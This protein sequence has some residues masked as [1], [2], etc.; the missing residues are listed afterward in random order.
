[1]E[2]GFLGGFFL[3]AISLS[4]ALVLA[5]MAEA[6]PVCAAA[7]RA[8]RCDLGSSLTKRLCSEWGGRDKRTFNFV[9]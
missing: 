9:Y 4:A 7:L 1:M 6:V 3:S 8:P 2:D 5:R